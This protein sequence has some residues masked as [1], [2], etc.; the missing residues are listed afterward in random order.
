MEGHWGGAIAV[1]M[2][3]CTRHGAGGPLAFGRRELSGVPAVDA[4]D[5]E[6]GRRVVR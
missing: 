3:G 6:H 2:C 1:R 4:A 5:E